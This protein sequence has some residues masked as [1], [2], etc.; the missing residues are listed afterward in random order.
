MIDH[1]Q[2]EEISQLISTLEKQDLISIEY[3]GT[4]KNSKKFAGT[5]HTLK[6]SFNDLTINFSRSTVVKLV[7]FANG[8]Q[9]P[10][11]NNQIAEPNKP[12]ITQTANPIVAI[13][14]KKRKDY[15]LKLQANIGILKLFIFI[16]KKKKG[17]ITVN[18]NRKGE[19]FISLELQPSS[20]KISLREDAF[21]M[22]E[23]KLGSF[24]ITDYFSKGDRYKTIAFVE[25][26]SNTIDLKL[27]AYLDKAYKQGDF[28]V[29]IQLTLNKIRF[30]I[31]FRLL[32]EVAHYF[33]EMQNMQMN[34]QTTTPPI[35]NF[36][37][38]IS[39]KLN[40][41][42]PTIVIP[43]NSFSKKALVVDLGKTFFISFHKFLKKKTKIFKQEKYFYLLRIKKMRID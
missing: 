4:P 38:K 17:N 41:Q 40:I 8:V 15:T 36:S 10:D 30:N 12:T 18:L 35:S 14:Q 20:A 16:S 32:L 9:V 39:V 21:L 25:E 23:G 33:L 31:I 37:P 27:E 11:L 19:R 22:V 2:K 3:E 1:S 34:I 42:S 28:D 24:V 26:K 29:S 5:Y 13:P 7:L 43:K 6:L